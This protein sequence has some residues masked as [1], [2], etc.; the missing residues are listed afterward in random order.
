[1]PVRG[2]SIS[3]RR[4]VNHAKRRAILALGLEPTDRPMFFGKSL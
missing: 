1:M 3:L 4:A 2:S